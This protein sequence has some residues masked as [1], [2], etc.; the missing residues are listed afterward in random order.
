[1]IDA[2]ARQSGQTDAGWRRFAQGAGES[3][4]SAGECDRPGGRPW[5]RWGAAA[6]A[7]IG[8][9]GAGLWFSARPGT[10]PVAAHSTTPPKVVEFVG[11][12]NQVGE[13]EDGGI[14]ADEGGGMHRV[15]RYRV[16]AEEVVRDPRNG[17]TVLVTQPSDEIVLIPVSRF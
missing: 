16:V 11:L 4:A 5:V 3:A 6:A 17:V 14:M 13:P 2:L 10:Q 15:V 8:V 1:M 7:V 12:T 9:L